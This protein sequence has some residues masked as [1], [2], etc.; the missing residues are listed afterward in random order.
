[1]KEMELLEY[2]KIN[3]AQIQYHRLMYAHHNGHNMISEY[4]ANIL[5][6]ICIH[7]N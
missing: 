3:S 5:V 7:L 1:M 4:P 2:G 6:L